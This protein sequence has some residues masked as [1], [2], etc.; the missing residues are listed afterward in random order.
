MRNVR[1]GRNQ[2]RVSE[3]T[4]EA[5]SNTIESLRK[6]IGK[7]SIV[8]E[9]QEIGIPTERCLHYKRD[10]FIPHPQNRN[11]PPILSHFAHPGSHGILPHQ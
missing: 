10:T 5:L 7:E 11:N 6:I 8:C 1:C 2:G 4:E 3:G 9:N